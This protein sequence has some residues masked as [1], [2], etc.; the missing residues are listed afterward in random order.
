MISKS[1]EL[2]QGVM[3]LH[4]P[5]LSILAVDEP[6]SFLSEDVWHQSE[7][8]SGYGMNPEMGTSAGNL[9]PGRKL[10][11]PAIVCARTEMLSEPLP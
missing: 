7:R 2:V 6:S 8:R 1:D 3:D 4:L 5:V 9:L 11:E 10:L